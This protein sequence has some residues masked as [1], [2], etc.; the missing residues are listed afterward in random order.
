MNTAIKRVLPIKKRL[1]Y[2]SCYIC[3]KLTV[4]CKSN[5]NDHRRISRF[6]LCSPFIL[7]TPHND[8]S[9][10]YRR[11]W[12]YLVLT[13]NRSNGILFRRSIA[14]TYTSYSVWNIITIYRFGE[15]SLQRF[16]VEPGLSYCNMHSSDI[17]SLS[18][19][20]NYLN[21]VK[22]L[23]KNNSYR[24]TNNIKL[25]KNHQYTVL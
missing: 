13:I 25:D 5:A 22:I 1:I 2:E 23:S 11:F 19:I 4:L 10:R 9:T 24:N 20:F 8:K 16:I 15:I 14:T 21:S 7:S 3:I 17:S 18:S 12:R 6:V